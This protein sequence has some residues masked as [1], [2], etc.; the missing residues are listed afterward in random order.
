M[1]VGVVCWVF[2]FFFKKPDREN[3]KPPPVCH[4]LSLP[5][6]LKLVGMLVL[7][8]KSTSGSP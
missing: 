6:S 7:L 3:Q 2:V 4:Q 1:V 8:N 5:A